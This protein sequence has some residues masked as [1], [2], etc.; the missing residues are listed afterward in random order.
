MAKRTKAD[1]TVDRLQDQ[2]EGLIAILRHVAPGVD[3]DAEL[4]NVAF[5]R[6]G[7]PVY[8]GGL[9]PASETPTSDTDTDDGDAGNNS[10]GPDMADADSGGDGKV[11]VTEKPSPTRVVGLR[12]A[13]RDRRDSPTV[14]RSKKPAVVDLDRMTD[15]ERSEHYEKVMQKEWR[16][17]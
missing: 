11:V 3:L 4:E 17:S 12:Y 14:S 5:R 9:L 15:E 1:E 10:D 6:D 2:L 13:G 16:A 8:I 7:T